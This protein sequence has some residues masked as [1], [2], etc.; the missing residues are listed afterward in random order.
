MRRCNVAEVIPEPV[1][2]EPV[3][4]EPVVALEEPIVE[5]EH[6]P[7]A[8]PA[9]KVHPL[10]P[11]GKRFEQVYAQGKQALRELTSERERR[12]AAEAKLEGLS[13]RPSQNEPNAE[14]EYTPAQLEEFIVQGRITRADAVAHREEVLVR[15]LS[16]K[17]KDDFTRETTSASRS[18]ALSQGIAGYVEVAPAIMEVGSDERMRLD[19]EFDWLVNV[20]GNDASKLNDVQRKTLQLT[21][22]RNVYGPLE[23]LKK[24][25]GSPRVDRT[26]GLPGGS[27]P[28]QSSNPDQALLDGL[29]RA[30]VTHYKK[31]METG[32]YPGKWKDVVEELKFV[33]KSRR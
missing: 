18:Q 25:S 14:V 17:I 3:V 15:K 13:N 1:V 11:G 26:E 20:S 12:I 32:R 33:P 7:L 9:G 28:R 21:A 19:Q 27:P 23:S 22:L 2:D 5:D 24:R 4:E 30:Q 6:E 10:Q 29:S 16:S 31:M 8:Q